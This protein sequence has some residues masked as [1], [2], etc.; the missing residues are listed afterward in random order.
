MAIQLSC[1]A[2]LQSIQYTDKEW[3]NED[4]EGFVESHVPTFAP[5]PINVK[6]T[7][8]LDEKTGEPFDYV[9][10][11]SG[12]SGSMVAHQLWE[13]GHRVLLLEMGHFPIPG[14]VDPRQMSNLRMEFGGILSTDGNVAFETAKTL[15]GGGTINADLVFPPTS[16]IVQDKINAW[17]ELG[18]IDSDQWTGW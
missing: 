5:S 11:G 8:L 1:P 18:R 7:V 4:V 9:I 15:G 16:Q 10:V 13:K 17:R 12:V 3:K 14:A 6:D 2:I